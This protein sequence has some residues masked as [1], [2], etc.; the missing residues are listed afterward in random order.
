MARVKMI[1]AAASVRR[2]PH[3]PRDNVD[4]P[5]D[6]MRL[7]RG[8]PPGRERVMHYTSELNIIKKNMDDYEKKRRQHVFNV[9]NLDNAYDYHHKLHKGS[10]DKNYKFYDPDLV[11]DYIRKI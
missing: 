9:L 1:H 4:T 6:A 11:A 2:Q 3:S 7:L 8:A 5:F 10:V